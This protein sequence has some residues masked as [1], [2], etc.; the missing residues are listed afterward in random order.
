[1]RAAV[2]PSR[3][4]KVSP[5]LPKY[6]MIVGRAATV[7]GLPAGWLC[8]STTG[9]LS[10]PPSDSASEMIR[11]TQY[12][13]DEPFAFQSSVSTDQVQTVI[14]R[15]RARVSVVELYEPPGGRNPQ[16]WMPVRLTCSALARSISAAW[17]E[18]DRVVSVAWSQVWL[19]RT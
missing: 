8:M 16:G 3:S 6:R 2:R 19:S 1:V 14:R 15:C 5:W 9:C 18:A 7:A 11:F 17:A 4:T 10:T 12:A 13:D